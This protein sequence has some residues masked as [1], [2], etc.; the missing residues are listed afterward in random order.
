MFVVCWP[1]GEIEALQRCATLHSWNSHFWFSLALAYERTTA[2]CIQP[3]DG[4]VKGGKRAENCLLCKDLTESSC[5]ENHLKREWQSQGTDFTV[6]SSCTSNNKV[7]GPIL[8]THY[9]D[10]DELETRQCFMHLAVRD[11]E[12]LVEV[13]CGCH[14]SEAIQSNE[15]GGV[16]EHSHTVWCSNRKCSESFKEVSNSC[17]FPSNRKS[18]QEHRGCGKGKLKWRNHVLAFGALVKSRWMT[19]KFVE[20][21]FLKAVDFLNLENLNQSFFAF[22]QSNLK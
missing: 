4:N 20:S 19:G 14:F 3:Q 15:C 18:L 16:Q 21:Q 11:Q 1:S 5:N 8:T 13:K 22:C 6:K 2:R 12:D 17:L 9:H 7:R 10:S